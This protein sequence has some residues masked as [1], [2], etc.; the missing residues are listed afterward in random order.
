LADKSSNS[1]EVINAGV[2]GT[3]IIDHLLY[4]MEKGRRT[5]PALVIV[6]FYIDDISDVFSTPARQP[7]QHCDEYSILQNGTNATL[8]SS[9]FRGELFRILPKSVFQLITENSLS[10]HTPPA[11]TTKALN[12]EFHTNS[13]PRRLTM[14]KELIH[15]KGQPLLLLDESRIDKQRVLWDTYLHILKD[16]NELVKRDHAEFMLLILPD[17]RQLHD[18]KNSPSAFIAQ[19]CNDNGIKYID[20]LKTFRTMYFEQGTNPFLEPYDNHLNIVG[21][22]A[23]ANALRDRISGL[24][25][26]TV[27]PN[28][29]L[30]PYQNPIKL[31]LD[32]DDNNTFSL[33]TNDILK[34]SKTTTSNVVVKRELGGGIRY[35]TADHEKNGDSTV[36]LN[37]TLLRPMDI[38]K[39]AIVFTPHSSKDN[40][41][42]NIFDLTVHAGNAQ[43]VF[44]TS[45][46]A[47]SGQWDTFDRL[48]FLELQPLQQHIDSFRITCSFSNDSGLAIENYNQPDFSRRFEIYLYP[49]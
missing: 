3:G 7:L 19:F 40:Q 4:Y 14:D 34:L 42:S 28:P 39:I 8:I 17:P 43:S 18:Y 38:D 13:I 12:D 9:Y 20:M 41:T 1:P 26:L 29:P 45:M 46:K 2:I 48:A 24:D 10:A 33:Q 36:E 21:N 5:K 44:S 30:N 6:Q 16:F 11:P 37:L 23:V 47:V 27:T 49:R 35:M 31:L 15:E 32:Y 22:R 25:T